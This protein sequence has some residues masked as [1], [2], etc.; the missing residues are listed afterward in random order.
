MC[1]I[2]ALFI[3][4]STNFNLKINKKNSIKQIFELKKH[5]QQVSVAIERAKQVT[6]SELNAIIGVS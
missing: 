3:T 2:S 6:M 4:R 1:T 5:Q